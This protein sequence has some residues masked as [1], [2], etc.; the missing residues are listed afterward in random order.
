MYGTNEEAWPT[1]ASADE[2]INATSRTHL[3]DKQKRLAGTLAAF[4]ASSSE[5]E[6]TYVSSLLIFCLSADCS[7]VLH[8]EI[9]VIVSSVA[10]RMTSL[11]NSKQWSLLDEMRGHVTVRM[12]DKGTGSLRLL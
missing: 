6:E 9:G 4:R 8:K 5:T 12:V 10:S 1:R 2:G 11:M 3:R 7:W